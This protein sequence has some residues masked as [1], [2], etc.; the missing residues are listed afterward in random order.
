M[1]CWSH[2]SHFN[3][4]HFQRFLASGSCWAQT[5]GSNKTGKKLEWSYA[6]VASP[7]NTTTVEIDGAS[8]ILAFARQC[9]T[10]QPCPLN[11][12]TTHPVTQGRKLPVALT[13][14]F[15]VGPQ[16]SITK[17]S[18]WKYRKLC[19]GYICIG[20]KRKSKTNLFVKIILKFPWDI[21]FLGWRDLC[22][23]C[24]LH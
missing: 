9:L 15:P 4:L 19:Y 23:N 21:C 13:S 24:H 2:R 20:R 6:P 18:K 5:Q 11:S 14:G 7:G 22:L 3:K 8:C 12:G 10:G 16:S 1:P 17:I